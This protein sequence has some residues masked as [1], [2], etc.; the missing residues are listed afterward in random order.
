MVE[1]HYTYFNKGLPSGLWRHHYKC[2]DML[3][4]NE[5]V[6]LFADESNHWFAN[7]SD[8]K[9][10]EAKVCEGTWEAVSFVR[11]STWSGIGLVVPS[12]SSAQ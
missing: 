11:A 3:P 7:G 1:M 8:W 2:F 9:W 4:S 6:Y 10:F 12:S 5:E